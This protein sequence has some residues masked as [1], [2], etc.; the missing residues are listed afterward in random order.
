MNELNLV[1]VVMILGLLPRTNDN[2]VVNVEESNNES[3]YFYFVLST[4]FLYIVEKDFTCKWG[5]QFKVGDV[6]VA[7]KLVQQKMGFK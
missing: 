4:Q 3:V 5:I 6:I 1:N 2:F 7:R